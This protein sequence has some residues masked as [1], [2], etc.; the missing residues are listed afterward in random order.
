MHDNAREL[1]VR[2]GAK[3]K[4]YAQLF[5]QQQEH[6]TTKWII[7][8]THANTETVDCGFFITLLNAA[9]DGYR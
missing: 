8:T 9:R 1:Y 6:R 7:K 5:C 3:T 4:F 2:G